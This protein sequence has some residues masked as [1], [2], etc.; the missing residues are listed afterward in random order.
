VTLNRFVF[1]M[2]FSLLHFIPFFVLLV[3]T[4]RKKLSEED[5]M[6]MGE[7]GMARKR[8]R[9]SLLFLFLFFL[10]SLSP[11]DLLFSSIWSQS[12]FS[13]HTLSLCL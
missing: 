5:Y 3:E 1:G 10:V 4:L 6:E 8:K 11:S 12:A 13:A 2:I 7:G 9:L